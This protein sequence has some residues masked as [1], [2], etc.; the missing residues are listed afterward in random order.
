MM[1]YIAYH[2]WKKNI[3]TNKMTNVMKS[4]MTKRLMTKRLITHIIMRIK[5]KKMEMT[6]NVFLEKLNRLMMLKTTK[7]TATTRNITMDVIL[8][9]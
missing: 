9:K 1:H 6:M 4:L 2:I 5:L 3:A 8:L 7:K